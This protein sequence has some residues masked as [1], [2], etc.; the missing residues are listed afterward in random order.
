M[1]VVE[2]VVASFSCSMHCPLE[3]ALPKCR[4]VVFDNGSV[5]TQPGIETPDN[6][7]KEIR[8]SFWSSESKPMKIIG[9]EYV[10]GCIYIVS[11]GLRDQ[12]NC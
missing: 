3:H 9:R 7:A 10:V 11:N 12:T 1:N 8:Q 4:Q 5:A 6:N 2:K